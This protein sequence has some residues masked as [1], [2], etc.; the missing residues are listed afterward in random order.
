MKTVKVKLSSISPYSQSKAYEVERLNKEQDKDY[1]ART[2]KE[3]LHTTETG[4]VFIPAQA[5][6]NALSDAAK[7]L[8]IKIPGKRN[9]TY[10]KHIEA[11]IL[12]VKDALLGIKKGEVQGE[13]LHVPSRAE[14]GGGTRV[15]KCFPII[16]KWSAEV[17]Y[18][19]LDETVTEEVFKYHLE[20][21]G[22]FIG[23]GRF[24]PRN[25]G[26]YGRFK[27]DKVSWN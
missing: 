25:N 16:P 3:R 1:E 8:S 5:F 24:R 10:T 7:Y 12:V 6:K 27:V 18:L 9:N 15:W 17:E 23:L 19:V 4:E 20:Q 13:W 26:Y 11:G 21:A 14:R 2:W 22:S